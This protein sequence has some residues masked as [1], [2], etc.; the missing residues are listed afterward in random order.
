MAVV[1]VVSVERFAFDAIFHSAAKFERGGS[2]GLRQDSNKFVAAVAPDDIARATGFAQAAR[3]GFQNA[4]A[5]W[6]AVGVVEK[7]EVVQVHHHQRQH[8]ILLARATQFNADFLLNR[9]VIKQFR[10]A[11][12]FGAAMRV[13]IKLSVAQRDRDFARDGFH[14]A[15]LDRLERFAL[16]RHA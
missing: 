14:D 13:L 3:H 16:A 9:A 10:N 11:V 2:V 5:S 12:P 4:I 6:M 15:A 8:L 1:F 7:L